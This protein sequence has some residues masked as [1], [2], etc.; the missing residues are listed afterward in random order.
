MHFVTWAIYCRVP[1]DVSVFD[2]KEVFKLYSPLPAPYLFSPFFAAQNHLMP[3][4]LGT[5]A[6]FICIN[7]KYYSYAALHGAQLPPFPT[8]PAFP[9]AWQH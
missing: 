5:W 9:D 3:I 8:F 6:N 2:T 4:P 7:N 1:F